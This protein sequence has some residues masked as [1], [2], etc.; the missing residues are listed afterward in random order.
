MHIKMTCLRK[1]AFNNPQFKFTFIVFFLVRAMII[2]L[3]LSATP[4]SPFYQYF[5]YLLFTTEFTYLVGLLRCDDPYSPCKCHTC[6]TVLFCLFFRIFATDQVRIHGSRLR[7]VNATSEHNG[8]YSCDVRNG[9]GD[10]TSDDDFLLN[11]RGELCYVSATSFTLKLYVTSFTLKLYVTLIE[12]GLQCS[13]WCLQKDVDQFC[14]CRPEKITVDIFTLSCAGFIQSFDRLCRL[15]CTSWTQDKTIDSG[16]ESIRN[17]GDFPKWNGNSRNLIN[18]WSM[19]GYQFKD[20]VCYP[21]PSG[22]V[23]ASQSLTEEA[24]GSNNLFEYS[25]LNRLVI[26]RLTCIWCNTEAGGW[27]AVTGDGWVYRVRGTHL[28]LSAARTACSPCS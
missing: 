22:A 28:S 21:C 18:H 19:N 13:N 27:N 7:I 12:A 23:V 26:R 3:P 5:L 15:L 2:I 11:V 14:L 17:N 8:V 24:A 20:S 1:I 6:F 10:I 25:R 16:E 4:S 9:A